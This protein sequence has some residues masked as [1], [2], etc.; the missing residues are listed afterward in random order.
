MILFLLSLMTPESSKLDDVDFFSDDFDDTD[1][2]WLTLCFLFPR[3]HLLLS[4]SSYACICSSGCCFHLIIVEFM[5]NWWLYDAHCCNFTYFLPPD[6]LYLRLRFMDFTKIQDI[7]PNIGRY[8][9]IIL[10][11][12]IILLISVKGKLSNFLT[13]KL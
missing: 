6:F 12:M 13:T 4:L 8:S 5:S 3:V 1:I 11:D 2:S 7:E 9:L 10:I